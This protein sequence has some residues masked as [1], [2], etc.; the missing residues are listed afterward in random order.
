MEV[1][2]YMTNEKLY[3]KIITIKNKKK[4]TYQ[5]IADKLG[6]ADSTVCDKLTRL[7][8]G[9]SVTTKFLIDLEKIFEEPIFFDN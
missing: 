7:K 3:K 2:N 6:I 1:E 4:L 5:Q 9:K 8:K